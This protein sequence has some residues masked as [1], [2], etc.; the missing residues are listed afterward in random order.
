MAATSLHAEFHFDF[1]PCPYPR[2]NF[3]GLTIEWGQSNFVNPPFHQDDDG[4]GLTAWVRKAIQEWKQGKTVVL[5]LPTQSYVNLLIEAGLLVG[6]EIRS[7]GRPRW[8]HTETGEPW[9]SPGP[10]SLFILRASSLRLS[11]EDR[12]ED[13]PVVSIAEAQ[14]SASPT[15]RSS[16]LYLPAGNDDTPWK[17]QQSFPKVGHWRG[18]PAGTG[19]PL[20]RPYVDLLV[21]IKQAQ[22]LRL[23]DMHIDR[24]LSTYEWLTPKELFDAMGVTFDLDPC[25]PGRDVTPWIPAR[26]F[27]TIA[28]DGLTQP[29]CGLVWMNCPYG[30]RNGILR[31][32]AKF[33]AH[34]D[35][36]ALVT[37]FTA[38]E[39]YHELI[40][41]A[42]CIMFVKP[43]IQFLPRQA[44]RGNALGSTLVAIGK[45]GISA[46][47]NAERNGRGICFYR[48][49][50][51]RWMTK[52]ELIA[53]LAELPDD[54][55]VWIEL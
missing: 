5:L 7:L 36:V 18:K 22:S 30:L 19:K 50:A 42:D 32:I 47:E 10:I 6:A 29:W 16:A 17:A 2:P 25:S 26:H 45:R 3:D 8:L 1:D 35:G 48:R 24:K 38:T 34:G 9:P 23:D 31:W 21:D 27:Y 51:G 15:E 33:V 28:D 11:I 37:D 43:K 53:A 55:R 14:Q 54:A 49:P 13:Q 4:S 40:G 41:N 52:R 12:A 39:W 20:A 44:G 46:L